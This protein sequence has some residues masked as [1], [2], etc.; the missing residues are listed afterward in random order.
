VKQWS[1]FFLRN[2]ADILVKEPGRPEYAAR[3]HK[4]DEARGSNYDEKEAYKF[5]ISPFSRLPA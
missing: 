4:L 5:F 3:R 2:V 1:Y